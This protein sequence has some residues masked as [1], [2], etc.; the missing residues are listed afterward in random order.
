[1]QK[2]ILSLILFALSVATA[3]AQTQDKAGTKSAETVSVKGNVRDAFNHAYLADTFVEVLTA[4]D[5]TVVAADSCRDY[6]LMYDESI[7]ADMCADWSPVDYMVYSFRIPAGDYL[8]R[9]TRKG[10]N[11]LIMPLSIPRKQH[12]FATKEW[13]ADD[14]ML[15]RVIE[16]QL[17]EATVTATQIMMVHR[18][19]TVVFN[20]DYFQLAQGNML[21]R[22]VSMLPGLEIKSGGQ[23]FYNGNLLSN[24]LVNGK[25]F[26]TGDPT[27]ALHNLPAYMVKNIKIYRRGKRDA[28]FNVH[29]DL[30]EPSTPNTLDVTLKRE[31]SRGWM[32]NMEAAAGQRYLGRLF[33][34]YFSDRTQFGLI[35]NCNNV[36]NSDDANSEGAWKAAEEAVNGI[37][38]R[39]YGGITFS[40]DWPKRGL[41]YN[42]HVKGTHDKTT[43]ETATSSTSFLQTGDVFG[44]RMN[45]ATSKSSSLDFHNTLEWR[46]RRFSI[47]SPLDVE[48]GRSNLDDR[49]LSAAF[50]AEP[51]DSYRCASLDSLF[52][53]TPSQHL[54][55]NVTNWLDQTNA[56]SDQ[57]LKVKYRVSTAFKSPLTGNK[58]DF[59]AEVHHTRLSGENTED[60]RLHYPQAGTD[61]VR[62]R[63]F[64]TSSNTTRAE[65][66]SGYSF[67]NMM[68]QSLAEHFSSAVCYKL[69]YDNA[70]ESRTI[71]DGGVLD[72]AGS[73][74]RRTTLL[75]HHFAAPLTYK[76]GESWGSSFHFNPTIDIYNTHAEDTRSTQRVDRR[77]A[78]FNPYFRYHLGHNPGG[79]VIGD[80]FDLTYDCETN[81]VSSY[82]LLD[83]HDATNPL[84]Q[85]QGNAGLRFPTTHKFGTYYIH[86]WPKRHC[87][88]FSADYKLIH[89][90]LAL[91]YTYNPATGAYTYRPENVQGNRHSY[92]SFKYRLNFGKDRCG[93]FVS[94]TDWSTIHSVDVVNSQ[95][96]VVDNNG[97]SE[98]VQFSYRFGTFGTAALH[99]NVLWQTAHSA[100]EGFIPRSS[101]DLNYGSDLNFKLPHDLQ[102]STDFSV[103]QRTGYDDPSM[104]D[105]NLVW[106][107]ALTWDF[108][109]RRA[110]YYALEWEE[111]FS[112]RVAGTGARPWSLR[113]TAHDLLHQLTGIRRVVNAQGITETW[114]NSVPSYVMVHLLYRWNK[115]PKKR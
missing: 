27:I 16:R 113:I 20:A 59:D 54:L 105:V 104:N 22:L 14:A 57:R 47:Y 4:N 97:L 85:M 55:D 35:A 71:W 18:G 21:D 40:H 109:F 69:T 46:T 78:F 8:L 110:S 64:K 62:N 87:I 1:M 11:E 115:Q 67:N 29:K 107:A 74:D 56:R 95:I 84:S 76:F 70:P 92:V 79:N 6:S 77:D 9:F 73:Y 51:Y 3:F 39:A 44:R 32:G 5:S 103:L 111:G 91:G 90:A 30:T 88:T 10:Y 17:G 26:F 61:D 34:L 33:A 66:W 112:H 37:M 75:K 93:S 36:S 89:D 15:Q 68:S 13:R 65:A 100:R 96:S 72:A 12:G 25:D 24:L 114:V 49:L 38:Q 19:D 82:Y 28:A 53:G 48:A 60:F 86:Q 50:S 7:R 43:T 98:N 58:L 99:A 106:N 102:F 45:N 108:D 52:A 63:L 23:I 94:T 101:F 31:Y 83:I 42:M 80:Y 81:P 2:V 41:K